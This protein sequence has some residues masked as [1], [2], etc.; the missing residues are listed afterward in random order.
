MNLRRKCTTENRRDKLGV[1][2]AK[3]FH[4]STEALRP[5]LYKTFKPAFIGRTKVIP[6]YPLSDDVL[7]SVIQLKLDRIALRV[8]TNHQ[9][10]L[11]Y[12]AALMEAVLARC[13]EVDTGARA[14]DHILNGTLLPEI[15]DSVL[16]RMAE[17]EA[18]SKIKVSAGKDGKF[19]FKV[20]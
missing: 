15:A 4:A 9:A 11:D 7:L 17:G 3:A 18:I 8:A 13:T 19:K 20:Q 12:D 14:V 2:F 16:A 6:Y 10:V 1:A 5:A